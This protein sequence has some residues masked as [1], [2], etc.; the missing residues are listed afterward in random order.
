VFEP[1]KGRPMRE[2]VLVPAALHAD[3]R[4]LRGWITRALEFTAGMPAKK[5]AKKSATKKAKKKKGTSR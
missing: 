1:M 5:P 2:Y 3:A 4:A